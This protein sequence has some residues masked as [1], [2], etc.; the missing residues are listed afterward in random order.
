MKDFSHF[1]SKKQMRYSH[2]GP[3]SS[4]SLFSLPAIEKLFGFFELGQF[5]LSAS[6]VWNRRPHSLDIPI[7]CNQIEDFNSNRTPHWSHWR[8]IR[9]VIFKFRQVMVYI[10]G[11]V[12][13]GWNLYHI[14]VSNLVIE[15]L[16]I[17]LVDP[18]RNLV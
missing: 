2:A 1:N 15:N 18:S 12:N 14:C 3:L 10:V 13:W 8:G 4:L 17:T 16:G 11:F 6:I 7:L 5:R 9:S